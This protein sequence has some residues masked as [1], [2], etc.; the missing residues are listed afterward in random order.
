MLP[1]LLRAHHSAPRIAGRGLL[2]SGAVAARATLPRA[3]RLAAYL[4]PALVAAVVAWTW[5]RSGTSVGSGDVSPWLR[6]GIRAELGSLW[7]HQQSG[8]GGTSTTAATSIEGVLVAL[9]ETLGGS[10]VLAQRF[11]FSALMALAAVGAVH[12]AR[13]LVQRPWAAAL[14]GL[15]A[16]FNPYMLLNIPNPIFPLAVGVVGLVVGEIA[17]QLRTGRRSAGRLVLLSLPV[18][19]LSTNPPLLVLVLLAAIATCGVAILCRGRQAVGGLLRLIAV[20]APPLVLVH[21]WWIVP[22]VQVNI[23]GSQGSAFGAV[24]DVQQ[25]QWVHVNNQLDR[26]VT[27]TAH[28][29]WDERVFFPWVPAISDGPWWW[30]R[31][32]LPVGAVLGAILAPPRLRRPAVLVLVAAAFLVVVSQGLEDPARPLNLLLYK[33]VPGWW[34]FRDPVT[35]FGAGLVVAYA[36]LFALFAERLVHLLAR[37]A[38]RPLLLLGPILLAPAAFPFPLWSG[39]VIPDERSGFPSAHVTVPAGWDE[40]ARSVSRSDRYGKVLVLPLN[41]YYQ[42]TTSWGYHGV[43]L[44][45]QIFDRPVLQILPGGYFTERPGYETLLRRAEQSL[46]DGDLDGATA[47][48]ASLGASHVVVRHD[49]TPGPLDLRYADDERLSAAARRLPGA[50]TIHADTLA[51]VVELS[52]SPGMLRVAPLRVAAADAPGPTAVAAA[53][54]RPLVPAHGEVDGVTWSTAQRGQPLTARLASGEERDLV[55]ELPSEVQVRA[56]HDPSTRQLLLQP[57]TQLVID[58][59][60]V[61][62]PPLALLE[63]G[64]DVEADRQLLLPSGERQGALQPFTTR[65]G[66]VLTVGHLGDSVRLEGSGEVGDCNRYD[67]RSIEEVGIAGVWGSPSLV[68]LQASDHSACTS[69]AVPAASHGAELVVP[70][71]VL[72]G[73]RARACLWDEEA[74]ACRAEAIG[75]DEGVLR[76]DQPAQLDG[77]RLFVYAEA[78]QGPAQVEYGPAQQRAFIKEASLTVPQQLVGQLT[79]TEGVHTFDARSS[80][81]RPMLGEWGGMEDCHAVDTRTPDEAGLYAAQRGDVLQLRARA[82]AACTI[83][84]TTVEPGDVVEVS[85]AH[86]SLSGAPARLCLW[87]EGPNRCAELDSLVSSKAWTSWHGSATIEPGTTETRLYLY[88]DGRDDGSETVVEYRDVE[89]VTAHHANFTL[90]PPVDTAPTIAAERIGPEVWRAEV[91]GVDGNAVLVLAESFAEGW[92]LDGLPEGW[93]AEPTVVDGWAMGWILAGNGDADLE[94]FFAPG[95]LVDLAGWVSVATG[96]AVIVLSWSTWR[97]HRSGTSKMPA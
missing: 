57:S 91:R 9:V 35:K 75:T 4:L 88:A 51:T 87:Q 92:Q 7:N 17:F 66:D 16:V 3:A 97:R 6:R 74:Q 31:W 84:P 76:L 18:A 24:T 83:A 44:A 86:R 96:V 8:A 89:V 25:W 65:P 80:Q 59:T 46:L 68:E 43:D 85:L 72:R 62:L 5:F 71:H 20:S 49:V 13:Q 70:F 52:D 15:V 55:V 23:L 36:V 42:V 11:W 38:T 53:D 95:R 2:G 27:L 39:E 60:S 37:K 94:L 40:I 47:I 78:H 14:A 79:L 30:L 73:E 63:V 54:G 64:D 26:V 93:S 12:A 50:A 67:S 77:L 32:V 69:L 21:A 29:A 22:F 61:P 48:A 19:Y 82:H 45:P 58:G 56:A 1:G 33:W 90:V 28:W 41:R 34:L 81:A 10:F